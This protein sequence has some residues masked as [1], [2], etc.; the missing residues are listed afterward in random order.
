MAHQSVLNATRRG[1][2]CGTPYDPSGGIET[3]NFWLMTR[4]EYLDYMVSPP[5]L[6]GRGYDE[7]TAAWDHES[8]VQDALLWEFPVPEDV[9]KDYPDMEVPKTQIELSTLTYIGPSRKF[10]HVTFEG[11]VHTVFYD[12]ST[13]YVDINGHLYRVVVDD[14]TKKIY[15]TM[16]A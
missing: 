14:T 1:D 12:F 6:Y 10:K 16:G 2:E 7:E 5:S 4:Q 3:P 13:P 15:G 11:K 9:L 8:Y